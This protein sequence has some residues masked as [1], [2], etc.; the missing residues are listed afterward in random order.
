MKDDGWDD[1]DDL[2]L[3]TIWIKK[4][5]AFMNELYESRNKISEDYFDDVKI[6]L[7]DTFPYIAREMSDEEQERVSRLLELEF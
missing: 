3:P 7:I 5:M 6:M 2:L 4:L 1:I